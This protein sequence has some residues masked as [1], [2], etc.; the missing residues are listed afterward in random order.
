MYTTLK[1]DVNHL[2]AIELIIPI[3]IDI[4]FSKKS[5]N[6]N[7]FELKSFSSLSYN[8][9]LEFN[10]EEDFSYL[11]S[12]LKDLFNRIEVYKYIKED[13]IFLMAGSDIYEVVHMYEEKVEKILKDY[14]KQEYI[15]LKGKSINT[16][17]LVFKP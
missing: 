9:K 2:N 10:E 4:Y 7:T 12:I 16:P 13:D 5:E 14:L 15:K 8:K 11:L 6:F 3:F 17:H 1:I